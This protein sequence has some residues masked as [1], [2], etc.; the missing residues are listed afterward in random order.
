MEELLKRPDT[1][2]PSRLESYLSATEFKQVFGMT[3]E[4][5][6]QMPIWKKEDQKRLLGL[7]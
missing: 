5:F 7:F 3:I 2:D 6:N 1:V 4:E